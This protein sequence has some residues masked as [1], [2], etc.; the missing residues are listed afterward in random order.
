MK[1]KH[2]CQSAEAS[3][4]LPRHLSQPG[5][6]LQLQ[7]RRRTR[8]GHPYWRMP[9]RNLGTEPQALT[10]KQTS[11]LQVCGCCEDQP[12]AKGYHCG[13]HKTAEACPCTQARTS[14]VSGNHQAH[15]RACQLFQTG[16]LA[17][18]PA[19]KEC[20]GRSPLHSTNQ[21]IAKGEWLI[22]CTSA[23]QQRKL[24]LQTTLPIQPSKPASI[25][26]RT[27]L[28][29]VVG[30]I[31]GVP[32]EPNAERLLRDD[33]EAQDL[34]VE[35]VKRLNSRTAPRLELYRWRSLETSCQLQSS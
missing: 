9:A 31:K 13:H 6:E 10:E 7:H 32:K 5:K 26:T 20:D 27:P 2:N 3:L 12:T 1:G 24:L 21:Q 4:P 16:L 29:V 8:S 15:R 11:P 17:T 22:G 30:V 25:N 34:H 28:N 33:F 18:G 35:S 19:S 14:R 23:Q